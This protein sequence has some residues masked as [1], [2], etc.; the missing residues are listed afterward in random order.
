MQKIGYKLTVVECKNRKCENNG[1]K[2]Y[3]FEHIHEELA[4]EWSHFK[5]PKK[6]INECTSLCENDECFYE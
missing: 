2:N 1:H 6:Y 4:I 5:Q 3:T